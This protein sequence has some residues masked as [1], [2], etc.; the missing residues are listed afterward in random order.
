MKP[1]KTDQVAV[2]ETSRRSRW[3]MLHEYWRHTRGSRWLLIVISV[4]MLIDGVLQAAVV[5]YLKVVVDGLV[6]DPSGFVRDKLVR[7]VLLGL[8][9]GALFFPAAYFGHLAFTVLSSRL[10]ASIRTHLYR[11]LQ[12]L[13]MSFYHENRSGD[14]IARLTGDVDGGAQGVTGLVNMCFWAL[15]VSLTSLVSMLWLS[16]RLTLIFVALNTIYYTVWHL[17]RKRVS[18]LARRVRDQ[19]GEV[20]AFATEGVSSMVVIKAFAREE[21]FIDRFSDVQTRLYQTQVDAARVSLAF[22]DILQT[23]GKFL[24]PVAILG[25]G[26]MLVE[27]GLTVG[28]LIAFWS[29]WTVVQPPIGALFGAGPAFANA[30]AS[31][32]RIHDFLEQAPSPADRPGARHFRPREGLIEFRNLTFA[33]P[34]RK[35]RP[36]FRNF[37]LV[38]PPRS[39]LGIVGPSGAGKSTLVQLILRFYDPDSGSIH[40]D[41]VDLRDMTQESLR[42]S[43]GVVLQESLLLSGTI[44]DNSLIG[45]ETANDARIWAALEQAGADEFVRATGAGLDAWVGERGVTLSGGQRQRLCIARV[46]LRN[47]PLMVF[48]EATSA[49]DTAAEVQIQQSMRRLLKGRTSILIAHRLSTI[50]ACDRILMLK[51]G[52]IMGLAPHRELLS[53]CPDYADLVAKQNLRASV[54]A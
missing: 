10:V 49:L 23:I 47:P 21:V 2:P 14:I 25:V 1:G 27:H 29:Y 45:D 46:F 16:W 38:I 44:R 54:E 42:R 41:G 22:S 8:L 5:N 9:A 34:G 50:A 6:A 52:A 40:L 28:T 11:H 48:D 19:A 4:A 53:V 13:S 51:D 20:N 35:D 26:A 17:Y 30:M 3:R 24:A 15:A 39:S 43:T 7:M 12:K 37:N 18:A 31:M 33:Y 36:V 32:D